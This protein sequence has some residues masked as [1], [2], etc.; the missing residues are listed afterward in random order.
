MG[1]PEKAATFCETGDTILPA[2]HQ[3]A[4]LRFTAL[5]FFRNA[6]LFLSCAE[7]TVFGGIADALDHAPDFGF[8]T[9]VNQG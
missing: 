1:R 5:R 8:T 7:A 9:K 4:L 6:S 3:L 2:S